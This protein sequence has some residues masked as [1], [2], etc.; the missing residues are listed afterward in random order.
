MTLNKRERAAT[1]E[2][3]RAN[4]ELAGL[5]EADLQRTLG[6]DDE[7]VSAALDVTDSDPIDV[8]LVRDYLERTVLERGRKPRPYS[9]LTPAARASAERWFA[10]YDLD[11]V[12]KDSAG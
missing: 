7:R 11:E 12:L 9:V 10:L 4:L 2:E 5:S 6:M 8:W 1:S 3:Q